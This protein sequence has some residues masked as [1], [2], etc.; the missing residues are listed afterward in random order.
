MRYNHATSSSR[1]A[2]KNVGN[3]KPAEDHLTRRDLFV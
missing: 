1:D 2:V 3:L